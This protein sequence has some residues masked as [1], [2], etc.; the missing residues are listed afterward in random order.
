MAV[1]IAGGFDAFSKAQWALKRLRDAGVQKVHTSEFRVDPQEVHGQPGADEG[2]QPTQ[3]AGG[4]AETMIAVN[5]EAGTISAPEIVRVFEECGAH[6]V[7][8]AEGIW[9]IGAWKDFDPLRQPQLVT[10]SE[11]VR[12]RT[13]MHMQHG[14]TAIS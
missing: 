13:D 14:Q 6:R 4:P 10:S 9:A 5:I 7:E 12:H 2:P 1:I 11:S 3:G 8:R